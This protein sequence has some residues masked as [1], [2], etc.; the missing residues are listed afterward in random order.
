MIR[1][2]KCGKLYD[3][4]KYNGICP[5]CAR[6]N[7]RDSADLEQELHEK[8]DSIPNAHSSELHREVHKRNGERPRR[9]GK[10]KTAVICIVVILLIVLFVLIPFLRLAESG[11]FS[12][13][14]FS[15]NRFLDTG[16]DQDVNT[17]YEDHPGEAY[18][19]YAWAQYAGTDVADIEWDKLSVSMNDGDEEDIAAL[20]DEGTGAYYLVTMEIQNNTDRDLDMTGVEE[21]DITFRLNGNEVSCRK[22]FYGFSDII[23]ADGDYGYL[24]CLVYLPYEWTDPCQTDG[25]MSL[26]GTADLGLEEPLSFDLVYYFE[27]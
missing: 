2:G 13:P 25:Y 19:E 6:Y 5:V 15:V 20:T 12:G 18:V 10:G 24:D 8:Y 23:E 21:A 9:G 1:C 16:D 26:S 11:R 14:D 3:Y 4:D 22:V 7:R 27:S 17:E